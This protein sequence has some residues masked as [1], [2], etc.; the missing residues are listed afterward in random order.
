GPRD[1]AHARPPER[2]LRQIHRPEARGDREGDGP[3]QV[4]R[5]RRGQGLRPHRRSVR[6]PARC[7]RGRRDGGERDL[8]R[9]GDAEQKA[10]IAES[11]STSVKDRH[12]Q[13]VWGTG[14]H[15][16]HP[17]GPSFVIPA[18]AGIPLPVL[19]GPVASAASPA[20]AFPVL[21]QAYGVYTRPPRGGGVRM[22]DYRLYCLDG[23]G[24]ISLA[25][26]IEADTD[27]EA[28]EK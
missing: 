7:G 22:G 25:D 6:D 5:D 2:A 17:S 3:R 12:A 1:P 18:E 10:E 14:E 4:P 16:D 13:P 15:G 19:L 20:P 24:R 9:V 21:I 27:D 8:E 23:E 11:F 28:I 26:W